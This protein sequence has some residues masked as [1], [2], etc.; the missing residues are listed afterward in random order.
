MAR[1][2][3]QKRV[4]ATAPRKKSNKNKNV[5]KKEVSLLGQAIRAL[6][7]TAGGA[8]GGMFGVPVAGA[9]AGNSLGASI[10]KWLGSGDYEVS[11]NSIVRSVRNS[12]SIP[13]MHNNSQSVVVRHKEYLGEVLSAQNFTVQGA[14]PLNP[15]VDQTFPWLSRIARRFQ[16]Y[17]FKGVVFHFVPTSGSI[18]STQALGSI[19]MQTTYRTTDSA[20]TSKIEMLNEY[21]AC[22]TVPADTVCH[23]I[24]CDPKENPFNVHYVRSGE[25]PSTESKLSYDLG[26]MY[27]ATS[28]QSTSGIVL[29]DLWVTYE[30]EL[31]KPILTSDA[32]ATPDY[33]SFKY[34]GG[35]MA[36][37]F[38]GTVLATAGTLTITAT[39]NIITFPQGSHGTYFVDVVVYSQ[40][41]LTAPITW[42]AD[43]T[44]LGCTLDKPFAD[45]TFVPTWGTNATTGT[46][47]QY[48]SYHTAVEKTNSS[49]V[50]TITLPTGTVAS[51]AITFVLL[52]V[53]RVD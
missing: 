22:E 25:V 27:L 2:R 19:M 15:G 47:I 16:E 13:M 31:K 17:A 29:G 42:T 3:K 35:A 11:Q 23:P 50:G 36:S 41:G 44:C 4:V 32:T 40:A 18:S 48:L 12:P 33:K 9:Q 45:V 51:G 6:G 7:A 53:A 1:A 10:S 39:G 24:E 20:P 26:T 14:Y 30:V 37:L 46:V 52:R 34:S 5:S 28:G 49:T 8:V 43:S 21:W 38:N